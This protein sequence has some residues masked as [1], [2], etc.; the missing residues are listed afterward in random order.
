MNLL[1]IFITVAV[2]GKSAFSR[3]S[4]ADRPRFAYVVG[5]G[6]QIDK[7]DLVADKLVTTVDLT[8]QMNLELRAHPNEGIDGCL[9]NQAA[10]D[11]S[12]YIFYT[13]APLQERMKPDGT[14]DYRLLGFQVPS[15][16]LVSN[17][18]AGG[19]LEDTPRLGWEQGNGYAFKKHRTAARR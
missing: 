10:F 11:E 16:R 8:K 7:L 6:A 4:L 1:R 18:S 5:C 12:K 2:L 9:A 3:I 13:V 15:L 17:R 14:K 19:N